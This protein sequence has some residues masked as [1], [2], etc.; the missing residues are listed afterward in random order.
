M[1]VGW[2]TS[3]DFAQ[4]FMFLH[5]DDSE[6]GFDFFFGWKWR[7]GI[8]NSI[9]LDLETNSHAPSTPNPTEMFI[10]SIG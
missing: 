1:E 8:L 4:I 3:L 6:N 2:S 5:K 10:A 9:G 7:T